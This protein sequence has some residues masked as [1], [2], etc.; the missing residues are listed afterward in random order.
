MHGTFAFGLA[1]YALSYATAFKDIS[2]GY[3]MGKYALA[4]TTDKNRPEVYC[5]MYGMVCIWKEPMQ[6]ILPEL[7]NAYRVGMEVQSGNLSFTLINSMLYI[8]RAFLSGSKLRSLRKEVTSFMHLYSLYKRHTLHMSVIPFANA[9]SL[10]SGGSIQNKQ[11]DD[12]ILAKSLEA[13]E[14][15]VC[16]TVV[17]CKMLCSFIFRDLAEAGKVAL[18]YLDFFEGH[19]SVSL[20]F[21]DIYRYF[22]GGLIAFDCFRKSQSQQSEI[23]GNT[24]PDYWLGVGMRSISKFETWS[25]ECKWNFQNKLLLL[26]AEHQFSSGQIKEAGYTYKLA[27]TSAREHRFVNEEALSCELAGYFYCATGSQDQSIS[28]FQQAVDCYKSWG[29]R[30]KADALRLSMTS[31]GINGLRRCCEQ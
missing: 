2:E 10:L 24:S 7:M 28:L 22:Y 31:L 27:I 9:I 23:T 25:M 11:E 4:I 13:R 16:E 15:A 29:A 14:L 18:E 19:G 17:V 20:Q 3:R 26:Q 30:K 21:I 8:Y 6:A 5:T 12:Q 1:S